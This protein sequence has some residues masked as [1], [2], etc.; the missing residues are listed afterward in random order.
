MALVL[1]VRKTFDLQLTTHD[2]RENETKSISDGARQSRAELQVP[3]NWKSLESACIVVQNTS[4]SNDQN[5]RLN[6]TADL[7]LD[8]FHGT[9]Q[10]DHSNI[11]M[12]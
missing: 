4:W 11:R 5:P 3:A 12:V 1:A 2:H 7:E 8:V 6:M 10:K 9:D